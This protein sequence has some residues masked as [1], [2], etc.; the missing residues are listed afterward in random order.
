M[1]MTLLP[2]HTCRPSFG[3][4]VYDDETF[5]AGECGCIRALFHGSL[6][7]EKRSRVSAYHI[8][9]LMNLF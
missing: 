3:M 5:K 4:C 6:V 1:A 8:L 7:M 9:V 2:E